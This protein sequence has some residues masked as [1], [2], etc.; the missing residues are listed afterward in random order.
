MR[1]FVDLLHQILAMIGHNVH[2]EIAGRENVNDKCWL[3]GVDWLRDVDDTSRLLR[4][5]IVDESDGETARLFHDVA[6]VDSARDS[7]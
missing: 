2:G 3:V 6:V 1:Q 7:K 5:E 4:A